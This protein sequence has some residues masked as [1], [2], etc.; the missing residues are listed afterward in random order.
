MVQSEQVRVPPSELFSVNPPP[1]TGGILHPGFWLYIVQTRPLWVLGSIWLATAIAALVAING[2]LKP[3]E[4]N[5]TQ[6]TENPD[7]TVEVTPVQPSEELPLWTLGAL[8]GG[9]MAGSVVVTAI[10]NRPPKSPAQKEYEK[11]QKA[12]SKAKAKARR[13]KLAAKKAKAKPV[14]EQGPKKLKPFYEVEVTS[15]WPDGTP[16]DLPMADQPMMEPLVT[17]Q[18]V[19]PAPVAAQ[20]SAQVSA[21]VAIAPEPTQPQPRPINTHR[22][23]TAFTRLIAHS[24]QPSAA[25]RSRQPVAQSSRP[26]PSTQP[27]ITVLPADTVHPLDWSDDGLAQ[28][29]DIRKQVPLSAW[30]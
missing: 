5:T 11:R 30:L 18:G 22:P 10:A 2:L 1:A 20:V 27:D 19:V 4:F 13:A 26:V 25:A 8:L 12:L 24:P 29:F 14:F 16:L 9:C 17:E 23:S 21:Q 7:G 6:I 28:A 15:L 3:A